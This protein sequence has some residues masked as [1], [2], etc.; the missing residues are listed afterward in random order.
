MPYVNPTAT[1][2]KAR[3]PAFAAVDDAIVTSALGEASGRVDQSWI[4][5]D[6][7]IAQMLYAA[8][9]MTLEGQ[10]DSD[11]NLFSGLNRVGIGPLSFEAANIS[12]KDVARGDLNTTSYGRRF[13]ELL[14]RNHVGVVVI[15]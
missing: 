7:Q 2:L 4:E 9:V 15:S 3:F 11:D 12:Q 13:Q 6:Y 5:S 14:R 8:H 10:G 1:D